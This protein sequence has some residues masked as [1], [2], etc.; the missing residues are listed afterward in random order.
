MTSKKQHSYLA[1]LL[2]Q[3]KRRRRISRRSR[4]RSRKKN[5]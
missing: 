1:P 4:S 2:S 3:K 5:L